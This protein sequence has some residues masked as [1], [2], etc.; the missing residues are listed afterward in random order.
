MTTP[1]KPSV[2]P[3]FGA[4]PSSY[5]SGWLSA[6]TAQL[7]RR[8]GLLAGPNTIQP[9]VLLQAPDG[10][11]YQVTVSNTGVLTTTVASRGTVQPPI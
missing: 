3:G 6:F 8:L 11:V 1:T 7:T 5:D 10:T 2:F 4:P 9:Q